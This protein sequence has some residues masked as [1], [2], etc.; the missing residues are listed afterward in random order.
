MEENS[1]NKLKQERERRIRIARMKK[2]I[3]GIIGIWLLF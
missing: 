2:S 1:A 3:I